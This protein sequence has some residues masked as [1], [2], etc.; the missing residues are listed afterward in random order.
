MA[1]I[2]WV[3][4]PKIIKDRQKQI[5]CQSSSTNSIRF[6][7]SP[8]SDITGFYQ[9]TKAG[10]VNKRANKTDRLDR[11]ARNLNL[12]HGQFNQLNKWIHPNKTP[13]QYL[14]SAVFFIQHLSC[15]SENVS[16][17]YQFKCSQSSVSSHL[18]VT[19]ISSK[20]FFYPPWQD[21]N[22]LI[23]LIFAE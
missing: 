18:S 20:T 21:V 23:T 11:R 5:P 1:K 12:K 4:F 6:P 2:T 8:L 15:R 17:I 3:T 10:E 13:V 14:Q 7:L 22:T 19:W 16:Q 9:E